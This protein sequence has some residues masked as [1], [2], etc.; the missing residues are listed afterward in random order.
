MIE[1]FHSRNLLCAAYL[2]VFSAFVLGGCASETPRQSA[3]DLIAQKNPIDAP[4]PPAGFYRVVSG[5]TLA[6]IAA[7]Y[8]RDTTAIADWN[9]LAANAS[10]TRGQLLR[11]GPPPA[12]PVSVANTARQSLK[13]ASCGPDAWSWPIKGPILKPFGSD[14]VKAVAI[15]GAA[16]DTVRAAQ[17]GRVVYTGD[18]ISGY[19]KLVILKHNAHYITA[20]GRNRSILVKEGNDVT[21]GQA[22]AT[23]GDQSSSQP[24][25]LFEVRRDRQPVDPVSF[26]SDCAS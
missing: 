21:K 10:L 13:T 16:G 9:G 23:L 22:I 15:G 8:G 18:R 11:V 3:P 6:S 1:S 12:S 5:D 24:S 20:Y 17:S 19:G 14:G 2:A 7:A 25:L 26:L 4:A